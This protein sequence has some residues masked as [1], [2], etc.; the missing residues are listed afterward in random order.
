MSE[1]STTT[2]WLGLWEQERKDVYAGQVIKKGEIP[3]YTR[4]VMR[5]NLYYEKGSNR[6]KFVYCFA[7]SNGYR[8]KCVPV[9]QAEPVEDDERLY[10]YE[11][12]KYAIEH[13]IEDVR[14]GYD[15]AWYAYL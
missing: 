4:I 2:K 8:D 13:I 7:D 14:N 1:E 5:K 11:E 12:V 3:K 15:V 9:E 10:T 6:P